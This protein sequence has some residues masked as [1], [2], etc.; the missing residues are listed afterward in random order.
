MDPQAGRAAPYVDAARN[1]A[2]RVHEFR[3]EIERQRTLPAALVGDMTD[4]GFFSLW[5]CRALGGPELTFTDF[6][7]VIE[8]LSSA[9]GSVGWCAMV[10]SVWSRLSRTKR[11]VN[12]NTRAPTGTLMKKIHSQPAYEVSTPPRS[13]PTAAPLPASAP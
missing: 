10:A 6:L 8:E 12:R 13:T 3:Q 4:A 11:G 7:N 5:R 1:L 9:D 2:P